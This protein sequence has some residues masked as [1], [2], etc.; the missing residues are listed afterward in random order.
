M[1]TAVGKTFPCDSLS[2]KHWI[3]FLHLLPLSW[4]II[5]HINLCSGVKGWQL[6]VIAGSFYRWRSWSYTIA[7][8][9]N[10]FDGTLPEYFVKTWN[11]CRRLNEQNIN[12]CKWYRTQLCCSA[13]SLSFIQVSLRN[14]CSNATC[15][16]FIQVSHRIKYVS[17]TGLTCLQC[18]WHSNISVFV[19]PFVFWSFVL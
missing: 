5:S 12:W 17:S 19:Q 7:K 2:I 10:W 1:P 9:S 11:F 14:K 16:F 4:I 6:P 3:N 15:I 18:R 8:H 13:T